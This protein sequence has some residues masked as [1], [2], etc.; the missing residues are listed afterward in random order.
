MGA[1]GTRRIRGGER[2]AGSHEQGVHGGV[3]MRFFSRYGTVSRRAT[4]REGRA[5][6]GKAMKTRTKHLLL[7]AGLVL[8][9]VLVFGATGRLAYSFLSPDSSRNRASAIN[10]T[11]E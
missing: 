11:L 7:A 4:A 6:K 8:G 10:G 2:V 9:S 5:P 3:W 1:L